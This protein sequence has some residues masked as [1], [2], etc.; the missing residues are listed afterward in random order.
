MPLPPLDAGTLTAECKM[1]WDG[2][3]TA[4]C[5]NGLGLSGWQLLEKLNWQNFS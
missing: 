4:A 1:P 3:L 5:C 2:E